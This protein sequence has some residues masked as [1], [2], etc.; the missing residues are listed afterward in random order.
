M[1]STCPRMM[2]DVTHRVIPALAPTPTPVHLVFTSNDTGLWWWEQNGP[3]R[4]GWGPIATNAQG[5]Q[6]RP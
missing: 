1:S 5:N 2:I 3:G 6:V 4:R